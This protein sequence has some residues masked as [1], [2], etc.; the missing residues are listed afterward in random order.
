M[1]LP[2]GLVVKLLISKMCGNLSRIYLG[3][4][5]YW[6]LNVKKLKFLPMSIIIHILDGFKLMLRCQG[7]VQ[8]EEK[9][10]V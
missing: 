9:K 4:E 3:R 8:E 5:S 6:Q 1:C 7:Y 10:T 2:V